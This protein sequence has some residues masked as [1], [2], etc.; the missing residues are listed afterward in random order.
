ML[1]KELFWR[2][3]SRISNC[4]HCNL[5]GKTTQFQSTMV[6]IRKPYRRGGVRIGLLID[7]EQ[8][9]SIGR[10]LKDTLMMRKRQ[11]ARCYRKG[12][13]GR[14]MRL[15]T[16]SEPTKSKYGFRLV[17]WYNFECAAS[18]NGSAVVHGAF[19][20]FTSGELF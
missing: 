9:L 17:L 1:T 16:P 8:I 10:D 19:A 3:K 5:A 14:L 4:C 2:L 11:L 6:E 18:I 20:W 15:R 7:F 13:Y 12:R